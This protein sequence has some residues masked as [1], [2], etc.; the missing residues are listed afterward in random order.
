MILQEALSKMRCLETTNV[1][2][3]EVKEHLSN[4]QKMIVVN[5]NKNPIEIKEGIFVKNGVA[6]LCNLIDSTKENIKMTVVEAFDFN[7]TT[8]EIIVS[9]IKSNTTL[10][11]DEG[12]CLE[13]VEV[14]IPNQVEHPHCYNTLDDIINDVRFSKTLLF[15]KNTSTPLT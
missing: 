3:S 1:S 6:F 5:I 10:F 15:F 9:I 14:I 4:H 13:D 8:L 12:G 2:D 11:V 7:D